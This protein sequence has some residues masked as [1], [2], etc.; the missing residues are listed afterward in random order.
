MTGSAKVFHETA[1][2]F[3]AIAHQGPTHTGTHHYCTQ[4]HANAGILGKAREIHIEYCA[5]W[6]D[7]ETPATTAT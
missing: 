6:T 4:L 5:E 1:H 2:L 7:E 3:L